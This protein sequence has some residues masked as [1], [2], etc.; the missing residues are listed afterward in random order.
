MQYKC[1]FGAGEFWRGETM[2]IPNLAVESSI[3]KLISYP[4]KYWCRTL[5]LMY[6]LPAVFA[7]EVLEMS[8]RT[9]GNMT[10][11]WAP[12]CHVLTNNLGCPPCIELRSNYLHK[13]RTSLNL[14]MAKRNADP[15]VSTFCRIDLMDKEQLAQRVR[16]LSKENSVLRQENSKLLKMVWRWAIS[17]HKICSTIMQDGLTPS[18]QGIYPQEWNALASSLM[19]V[20]IPQIAINISAL[21]FLIP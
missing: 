6:V 15:T 2:P 3:Q 18:P 7:E 12:L 19:C 1:H 21:G 14:S 10:T 16:D 13:R 11:I 5:K 8:F 4:A 20:N 9:V 17:L